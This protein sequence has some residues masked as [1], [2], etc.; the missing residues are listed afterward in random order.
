VLYLLFTVRRRLKLVPFVV[1]VSLGIAG[2]LAMNFYVANF[3]RSGDLIGRLSET[4]FISG[5]PDSRAQAWTVAWERFLQHPI[6]GHGPFY[7]GRTGIRIWYWPHNV[8]LY[9]ANLVGIVG[10]SFYLL[11]LA[12][13][14]RISLPRTDDLRHPSYAKAFLIVANAQLLVFAVDQIKIDFLRNLIYQF[15]PWILFASLV[16]AHRI[17]S[18]EPAEPSDQPRAA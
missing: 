6:I 9:I 18:E 8:Y 2:F 1:F 10:L 5:M 4:T 15:Q 7:S 14:W 16:V 12:K 3:T 13:L 17:A 11:L